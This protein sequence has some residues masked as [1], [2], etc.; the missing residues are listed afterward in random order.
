MVMYNG[1][2]RRLP[3]LEQC[4]AAALAQCGSLTMT[5]SAYSDLVAQ[6][7]SGQDQ[8]LIAS[9]H[10]IDLRHLDPFSRW[11]PHWIPANHAGNYDISKIACDWDEFRRIAE[12]LGCQSFTALGTYPA[13][14]LETGELVDHF[15]TLCRLAAMEGLRVDL[16]F[17][18][19]WG[20]ATLEQAWDIVRMVSAENSG[21]MFD[22]W[23]FRR[24]GSSEATLASIPGHWISGVQLNDGPANVPPG[25]SIVQ[26]CLYHRSPPGEGDFRVCELVAILRAINGLNNVGPEIFSTAFDSLTAEEIAARALTATKTVLQQAQ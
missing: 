1:T 26:D 2:V 4:R 14:T 16:E 18:P 5:P 7:V 11:T 20:L 13:G 25:R 22:T 12:A 3:F 21:I 24:S 17:A 8:Q 15:G 19:L 23:H 6:G 9:D 10:G